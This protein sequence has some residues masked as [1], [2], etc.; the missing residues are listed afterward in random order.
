MMTSKAKKDENE[1]NKGNNGK[2]DNNEAD[3]VKNNK[4]DVQCKNRTDH[5]QIN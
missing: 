5:K 1:T 2:E 3:K 4:D